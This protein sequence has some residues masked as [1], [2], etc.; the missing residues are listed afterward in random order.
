MAMKVRIEI[1][2]STLRGIV[3]DYLCKQFESGS[4]IVKQADIRIEVKSKQN[5]KS[6]WESA[7]FRAVLE[8]D[9]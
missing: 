1:N 7:G 5:Y 4:F 3:Q 8:V 2:E 6:E 9:Q